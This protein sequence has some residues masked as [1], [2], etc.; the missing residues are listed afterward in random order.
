MKIDAICG[1]CRYYNIASQDV[2][3]GMCHYNPPEPA[4]I[5][6]D[7]RGPQIIALRPVVKLDEMGCSK[8][9]PKDNLL[10]P[11]PMQ[12]DPEAGPRGLS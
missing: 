8:F 6:T 12:N 10:T 5:G 3:T 9:H 2:K 4:M 11:H 1:N 7:P